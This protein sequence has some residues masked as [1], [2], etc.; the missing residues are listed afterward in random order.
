MKYTT[1]FIEQTAKD[2]CMSFHQVESEAKKATSHDDFYRKLE[3][4]LKFMADL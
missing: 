4:E 3:D 2:Y 1:N